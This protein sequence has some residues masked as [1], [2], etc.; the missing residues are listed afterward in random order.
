MIAP[1]TGW[2]GKYTVDD[3]VNVLIVKAAEE[4]W[5][6][7]HEL[8]RAQHAL[9]LP[10]KPAMGAVLSGQEW[11]S[12]VTSK[13]Y[14]SP[15]DNNCLRSRSRRS[16]FICRSRAVPLPIAVRPTILAP[17]KQKCSSHAS[18][19]GLHNRTC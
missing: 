15:I 18:E 1:L 17:T 9:R 7:P 19:R 14:S 12:D 10:G 3:T 11:P 5:I 16:L 2:I 8:H 4:D 13:F 6:T